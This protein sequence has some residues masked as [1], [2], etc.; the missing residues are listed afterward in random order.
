MRS[1]TR[2]MRSMRRARPATTCAAPSR[3]ACPTLARDVELSG[4]VRRTIVQ[5]LEDALCRSAAVADDRGG[6]GR[7]C[8]VARQ[9]RL[10]ACDLIVRERETGAAEDR[11]E[12]AGLGGA[13]A[14][15]P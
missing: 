4:V 14:Q 5:L 12:V 13:W 11:V 9:T 7:A 2:S 6:V 3:P 1:A 10:H 15:E 8:G